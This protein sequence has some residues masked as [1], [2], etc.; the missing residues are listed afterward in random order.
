MPGGKVLV[1]KYTLNYQQKHRSSQYM[2]GNMEFKKRRVDLSESLFGTQELG[3]RITEDGHKPD[4]IIAIAKGGLVPARYL[5]KHLDIREI[6]SIGI[7]FYSD[8]G[9][10]MKVPKVYQDL[11][12]DIRGSTAVI[13]DDILDSGDSIRVAMEEAVEAGCDKIITCALHYKPRSKYKPNYFHEEV[14]NDVWIEYD[15]E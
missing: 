10:T 3:R 2:D 6:Y 9:E 13:C 15:W 8:V 4:V 7:K 1:E 11:P 12:R 14:D 5:A